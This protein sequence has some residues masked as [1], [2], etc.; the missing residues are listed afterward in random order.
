MNN[1][2]T[3]RAPSIFIQVTTLL[4]QHLDVSSSRWSYKTSLEEIGLDSF[5][6]VDF[7]F[8]LEDEFQIELHFQH[9]FAELQWKSIGAL[10]SAVE[11]QF[12]VQDNHPQPY[13]ARAA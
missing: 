6:I 8:L 11:Q 1:K 5:N 12:T 4:G 9:H 7:I 13:L 10:V 3:K 2:N